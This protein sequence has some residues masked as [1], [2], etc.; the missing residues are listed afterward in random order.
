MEGQES[1]ERPLLIEREEGFIKLTLNRPKRL[2]SFNLALHEAMQQALIECETATSCRVVLITGAG[3]AF[4]AGQDLS[5]PSVSAAEGALPDLAVT[6]ERFYNPMVRRIRAMN[7]PVIC[8]VNGTAAGAGANLALACDIVLASSK[9]KF[10]QPFN[11]IGLIPDTGGSWT[12]TRLV[13]EARAKG[14]TL[15]GRPITA[16]HAYDMG[17]IWSVVEP[18]ALMDAAM[19]L[20]HELRVAPT[21][22]LAL[23]K[24]AIHAAATNTLDQQLDLER[25]LQQRAGRS[26]DYQEGVAAFFEKRPPTF[27]GQEP[28]R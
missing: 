2:N 26:P 18:D 4:C 6:L 28:E 22:G 8:A 13:G 23:T 7:K 10:L 25:D 27:T 20:V 11:K 19:A 24:Q 15:L 5:D 21:F 17:L 12:L 1:E 3:R 14:L 16:Q 9:A